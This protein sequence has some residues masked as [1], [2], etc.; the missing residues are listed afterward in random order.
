[1]N[2]KICTCCGATFTP[3]KQRQK[4]CAMCA[5][6][7]KRTSD[8][9]EIER[10]YGKLRKKEPP[11][12]QKGLTI[13]DTAVLQRLAHYRLDYGMIQAKYGDMSCTA[14]EIMMRKEGY[15]I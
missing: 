2:T 13:A 8:K 15:I 11:K 7:L 12:E 10:I 5:N 4:Y 3:E 14:A 6:P 1:M 9:K